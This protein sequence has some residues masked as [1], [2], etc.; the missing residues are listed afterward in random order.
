MR[1]ALLKSNQETWAMMEE[2]RKLSASIA[3]DL[4][5]PITVVKG[6]TEYLSH[7]VPSGR[8]TQEKNV[9]YAP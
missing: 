9:G 6:Y 2:R 8:I 7:N 3:H 5:T 4:R 1:A